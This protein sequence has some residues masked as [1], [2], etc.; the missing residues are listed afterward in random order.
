M[1]N[2]RTLSITEARKKIFQIVDDVNSVN[3]HY[4]LT[5]KGIPKVV[6]MSVEEFESW[7]ETIELLEE[8][9]NI[10]KDLK[11]AEEEIKKGHYYTLDE[12]MEHLGYTQK[13]KLF[14]RDKS[15]KKYS[16]NKRKKG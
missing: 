12:V 16:V 4:T 11:K 9:P 1:N 10:F 3:K 8:D 7:K 6:L 5:E 14:L 15:K 13:N 2:S